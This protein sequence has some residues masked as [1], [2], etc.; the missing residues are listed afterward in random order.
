MPGAFL[1]EEITLSALISFQIPEDSA[2]ATLQL[3]LCLELGAQRAPGG[4]LWWRDPQH[5]STCSVV[6]TEPPSLGSCVA[7]PRKEEGKEARHSRLSLVTAQTSVLQREPQA[8]CVVLHH[9]WLRAT[10]EHRSQKQ[11]TPKSLLELSSAWL[12]RAPA[13]WGLWSLDVTGGWSVILGCH[14]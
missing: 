4:G 7:Y 11:V 12:L 8:V 13:T 1:D 3:W 10:A 5:P 6:R 2:H 9:L 14:Y